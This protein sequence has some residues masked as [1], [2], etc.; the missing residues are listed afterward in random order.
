MLRAENGV[1]LPPNQTADKKGP[2]ALVPPRD[3]QSLRELAVKQIQ[4]NAL[5]HRRPAKAT[6]LEA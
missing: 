2:L 3:E 4:R 6:T 5:R 1:P